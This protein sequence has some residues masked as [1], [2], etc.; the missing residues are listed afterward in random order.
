MFTDENGEV[1]TF[2]SIF[3]TFLKK[4]KH[5]LHL[6]ISGCQLH[7]DSL[8][9][10]TEYGFKKNKT[11]LSIHLSRIIKVEDHEL[12]KFRQTLGVHQEKSQ[13]NLAWINKQEFNALFAEQDIIGNDVMLNF[14]SKIQ[15][16]AKQQA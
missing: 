13:T 14:T 9:E 2:E 4:T 16:K 5:L 15:Y 1:Q 12:Q 10:I 6:N 8:C 11:L 7:I 3:S